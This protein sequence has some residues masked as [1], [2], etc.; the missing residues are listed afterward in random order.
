MVRLIC[1]SGDPKPST[2][3]AAKALRCKIC[4]RRELP[5]RVRPTKAPSQYYGQFGEKVLVDF[6]YLYD[7]AGNRYLMLGISCDMTLLHVMW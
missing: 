6:F 1:N 7:Y 3:A 2:L 4:D 5:T